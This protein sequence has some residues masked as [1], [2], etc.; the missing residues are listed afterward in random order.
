MCL[1]CNRTFNSLFIFLLFSIEI[2]L[3]SLNPSDYAQAAVAAGK[4]TQYFVGTY[5]T[6][7]LLSTGGNVRYVAY[8]MVQDQQSVVTVELNADSIKWITQV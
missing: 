2:S 6:F 4:P 7:S 5:G 8:D 3:P 1:L